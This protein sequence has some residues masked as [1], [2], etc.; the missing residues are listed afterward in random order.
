MAIPFLSAVQYRVDECTYVLKGKE[1]G[2]LSVK[3]YIFGIPSVWEKSAISRE[4]RLDFGLRRLEYSTLNPSAEALLKEIL[5]NFSSTPLSLAKILEGFLLKNGEEA[6]LACLRSVKTQLE[7]GQREKAIEELT[8]ALQNTPDDL[9]LEL[10][11]FL[12]YF[13]GGGKK[14]RRVKEQCKQLNRFLLWE[15]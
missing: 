12:V 15:L 11:L 1:N 6:K 2:D 8:R 5:P 14:S 13:E 9:D 7:A 10:I 4:K 3:E